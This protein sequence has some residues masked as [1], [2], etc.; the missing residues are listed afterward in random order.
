MHEAWLAV[1]APVGPFPGQSVAFGQ[2]AQRLEEFVASAGKVR[3]S[4]PDPRRDAAVQRDI[5]TADVSGGWPA[6]L[7]GLDDIEDAAIFAEDLTADAAR[8]AESARAGAKWSI[9][10]ASAAESR[11]VLLQGQV[12]CGKTMICIGACL[13]IGAMMRHEPLSGLHVVVC[14]HALAGG[15]LA[16]ISRWRTTG[17]DS[18]CGLTFKNFRTR[19]RAGRLPAAANVIV[20]LAPESVRSFNKIGLP[21]DLVVVDEA[22][23]PSFDQLLAIMAIPRA[24][25]LFATGT[26]VVNGFA[27]LRRLLVPLVGAPHN[28]RETWTRLSRGAAL[29][30]LRE[31]KARTVV[32][33]GAAPQPSYAVRRVRVEHPPG[34]RG[35]AD[36]RVLLAAAQYGSGGVRALGLLTSVRMAV[37]GGLPAPTR[38]AHFS[39]DSGAFGQGLAAEWFKQLPENAGPASRPRVVAALACAHVASGQIVIVFAPF[40]HALQ[41]VRTALVQDHQLPPE[42]ID[43]VDGTTERA[44]SLLQRYRRPSGLAE[45]ETW[46]DPLQRRRVPVHPPPGLGRVLLL[47]VE[48]GTGLTLCAASVVILMG[49]MFTATSAEQ[50]IGRV[51]RPG[52][53]APLVTVYTIQDTSGVDAQ[54]AA[55]CSVKQQAAAAWDRLCTDEDLAALR[56]CGTDD[57]GLTSAAIESMLTRTVAG[58]DVELSFTEIDE[59]G[60]QIRK[61]CGNICGQRTTATHDPRPR[62]ESGNFI[63][64]TFSRPTDEMMEELMFAPVLSRSAKRQRK[65]FE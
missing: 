37:C 65:D 58:T 51:C 1:V 8:A 61:G 17:V 53:T 10:H 35:R 64:G 57:A 4:A 14:P 3:V 13:R 62:D 42:N 26:P 38:V 20:V 31:L 46:W 23:I 25:L 22:H 16:E 34:L 5:E 44:D 45:A 12:G 39:P 29:A 47:T 7:W 63:G 21:A 15:W 36:A 9:F 54:L 55:L 11:G 43:Y 59:T 27:D 32:V 52:Q 56:R 41:E 2:V 18:V 28:T 49:A 60:S 30:E 48:F 33:C 24:A 19:A 40:R 50:C 6:G